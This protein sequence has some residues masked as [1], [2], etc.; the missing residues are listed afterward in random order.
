MVT[1]YDH[2]FS[3]LGSEALS[4]F[5]YPSETNALKDIEQQ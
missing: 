4:Q 3:S 2:E 1:I 5:L